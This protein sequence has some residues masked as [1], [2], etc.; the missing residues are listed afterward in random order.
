MS[1]EDHI[2]ERERAGE[3]NEVGG[4]LDNQTVAPAS[5]PSSAPVAPASGDTSSDDGNAN[6]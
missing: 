4:N 2:H 5:A 3:E 1:K 6:S